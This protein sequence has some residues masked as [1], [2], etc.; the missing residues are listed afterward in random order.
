MAELLGRGGNFLGAGRGLLSLT[1]DMRPLLPQTACHAAIRTC[2][3]PRGLADELA[4]WLARFAGEVLV[5]PVAFLI[6]DGVGDEDC[7]GVRLARPDTQDL[8]RWVVREC[9]RRDVAW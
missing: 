9:P 2:R 6:G 5:D 8:G 7:E 4:L 1:T 3:D